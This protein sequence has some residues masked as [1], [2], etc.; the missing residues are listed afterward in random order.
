MISPVTPPLPGFFPLLSFLGKDPLLL[1]G[2]QI[3]TTQTKT[4]QAKLKNELSPA[5]SL[6]E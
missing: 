3:K 6:P 1:N 4:K 5:P 2:K